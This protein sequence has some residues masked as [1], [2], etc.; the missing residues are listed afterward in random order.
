MTRIGLVLGAGGIVGQ[1]YHAGVLAALENDL[2]WDPRTADVI[3]GSSAGSLTGA[4]LRL[5]VPASDLAAYAVEAPLTLESEE[6]VARIGGRDDPPVFDRPSPLHMLRPWRVPTPSLLRRMAARPSTAAASLSSLLPAGRIDIAE[7][8]AGLHELAGDH[9]PD[10]LRICAVRRRDGRRVV[11]GRDGAPTAPLARAVAA[12]C[13][14]PGFFTPVTIGGEAYIDGGAHSPTN[15]DVIRREDLDL[16]VAV[17]P[18]SCVRGLSSMPDAAFRLWAHRALQRELRGFTRRGIPV[19]AFEPG[20]RALNVMG[21][22]AMADDRSARVVQ[23]A[24]LEAGRRA[25]SAGAGS[26]LRPLATRS[27]RRASAA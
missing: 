10:G 7:H 22:N 12:S 20:R 17:S 11:F 21:I 24:F 13:A 9:W 25:A 26:R 19:V 14:I 5:G 16:V 23:A 4:L 1:A 15:A 18:M 2:G 27:S 6:L 3:V 8:I